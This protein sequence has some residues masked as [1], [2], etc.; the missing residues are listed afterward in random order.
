MWH[1]LVK[2]EKGELTFDSNDSLPFIANVELNG[3]H[4]EVDLDE[5]VNAQFTGGN[6]PDVFRELKLQLGIGL[7][8]KAPCGGFINFYS[9]GDHVLYSGVKEV[10]N[11]HYMVSIHEIFEKR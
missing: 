6:D 2:Y 10:R 7:Y 4:I 5:I 9:I 1:S 11:S 8:T 3:K